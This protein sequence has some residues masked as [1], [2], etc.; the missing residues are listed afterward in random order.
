MDDEIISFDAAR[1]RL[2][3]DDLVRCVRCKKMI[4]ATE[5]R[6]PKCGVHFQGQAYEFEKSADGPQSTRS[7]WFTIAAFLALIAVSSWIFH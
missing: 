7:L 1:R 4:L 3:E 5:A 6:C 2:E